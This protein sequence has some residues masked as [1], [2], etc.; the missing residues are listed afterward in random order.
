LGEFLKERL[1]EQDGLVGFGILNSTKLS[2]AEEL[3][4]DTHAKAPHMFTD[5]DDTAKTLEALHHL[6]FEC[7][8]TSLVHTFE[9][10]EHFVT[11][12][13]ERNPSLSANCNVLIALLL[14]EDGV[15]HLPQIAKVTRYLTNVAFKGKIR[16]K[17]VSHD[18]I[19]HSVQQY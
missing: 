13:G 15:E 16:E 18:L 3:I 4:A 2:S 8:V 11:Y 14:C 1:E 10:S 19:V 6:G 9:S 17:W 7:S 12:P 5:V